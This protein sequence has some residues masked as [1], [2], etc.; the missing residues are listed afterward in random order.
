MM[1]RTACALLTLVG[2]LTACQR[3][4]DGRYISINGKIFIFNIRLSK[5]YYTL[6][7]NRLANV[8]DGSSV[9]AEFENPAGGPPLVVTQKVFPK[10]TR[11]DFESPDLHCIVA[12]RP[13]AIKITLKDPQGKTLQTIDTTLASTLDQSVMPQ[14]ALVQGNAYDRNPGA[15]GKDGKIKFQ[16]ACGTAQ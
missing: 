6:N 2:L 13:Y 5:A 3:A 1:G 4:E 8:A 11:I 12:D 14:Q 9:M 10:M 15:Y 7:I 16:K